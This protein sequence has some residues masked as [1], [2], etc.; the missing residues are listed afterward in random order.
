MP[1]RSSQEIKLFS[2]FP[3]FFRHYL[4]HPLYPLHSLHSLHVAPTVIVCTCVA[5]TVVVSPGH[6]TWSC[7]VVTSR[8]TYGNRFTFI[9][10]VKLAWNNLM[11][12]RKEKN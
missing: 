11:K 8:S 5:P 3:S 9:M 2:I 10:H 1:N 6:V 12:K 7:H 4:R